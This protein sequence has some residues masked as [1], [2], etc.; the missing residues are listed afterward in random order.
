MTNTNHSIWENKEL[1][2]KMIDTIKLFNYL[3][4]NAYIYFTFY[5]KIYKE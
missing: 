2:D 1:S 5:S 4:Y 3:S